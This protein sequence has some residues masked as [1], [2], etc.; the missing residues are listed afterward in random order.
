MSYIAVLGA[1]SWGTALARMLSRKDFDVSIWAYEPEVA[2]DINTNGV[3]S[4]YLPGVELP[5]SLRCNSSLD[6]A[7]KGARY[8][9]SAVP[10]QFT[11]A[12]MQGALPYLDEEGVIISVSKGIEKETHLTVSSVIGEITRHPV[13]VL[14]GPSFAKEVVNDLPTAVTLACR[15]NG[16]GVH[17]QEVFTTDRFRVYTHH[18][19]IGVELGGALKNVMAIASGIAE[20]LELGNS[21]RASLITR[22]LAEMKRLGVSMGADEMTFSGLSGLGDLVLTCNSTLSRNFTVGLRLGRGE[23]LGDIVGSTKS[24]AEGVDTT[25]SAY[26]LAKKQ[27]VEMPIVEQVY[28]VLYEGRQPLDAVTSLMGRLPKAEFDG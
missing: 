12:V 1:G 8:V 14:S 16:T 23:S 24:V 13:A 17:I 25:V 9:V 20:G 11:R 10:S 18:D 26:E 15:E 4:V 7:M 19:L 2:E 5:P 6:D 21:A 27:N 3:N 22:G 28:S